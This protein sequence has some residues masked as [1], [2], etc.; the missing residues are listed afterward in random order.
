MVQTMTLE[1]KDIEMPEPRQSSSYH[2]DE[3][4]TS[5][6]KMI[7]EVAMWT[8]EDYNWDIDLAFGEVGEQKLYK[9]LCLILNI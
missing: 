6:S 3:G 9:I 2:P 8:N 1:I 4:K 5:D 7:G